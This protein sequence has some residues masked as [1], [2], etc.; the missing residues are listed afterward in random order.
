[1]EL[2]GLETTTDLTG[3]SGASPSGKRYQMVRPTNCVICQNPLRISKFGPPRLYCSGACRK[4]QEYILQ[5]EKLKERGKSW[6]SRNGY[7]NQRRQE[8]RNS[9]N[10][11]KRGPCKDCGRYFDP[12]CM[13]FDHL[14][15]HEKV[16]T[17]SHLVAA[18]RSLSKMRIMAEIAKCDLVCACCHRIR[19]KVRR[20]VK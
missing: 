1:M 20:S 6:V 5:C 19:T 11:I 3:A 17:V 2:P 9:V 15:G 12:V 18:S 14:P 7:R 16:A 10:E 13:D 4:R 8:I